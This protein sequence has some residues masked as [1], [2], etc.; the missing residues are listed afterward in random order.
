M[1][2]IT[3]FLGNY[4]TYAAVSLGAKSDAWRTILVRSAS[5]ST[6]MERTEIV[7]VR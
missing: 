3:M 6:S 4:A 7:R 5:T 1:E 2:W